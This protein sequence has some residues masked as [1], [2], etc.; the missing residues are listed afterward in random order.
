MHSSTSIN[1]F[2]A[3]SDV[4]TKES[5]KCRVL[6]SISSGGPLKFWLVL[7]LGAIGLEAAS[8][9]TFSRLPLSFEPLG[10]G[11][12]FVAHAGK[13]DLRVG[14][15]GAAL[16]HQSMSLRGANAAAASVAEELLPGKTHYLIGDPSQWRVN[17]P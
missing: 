15:T 14:A 5:I 17:V 3:L 11:G 7:L 4:Q 6:Q 12:Q 1:Q 9:D 13:F 16:G 10:D 2:Y 8:L